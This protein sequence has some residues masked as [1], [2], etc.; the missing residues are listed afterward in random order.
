MWK[1]LENS[2]LNHLFNFLIFMIPKKIED[3]KSQS[4]SASSCQKK[5]AK[6]GI[7]THARN[8]TRNIH[9]F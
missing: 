5:M 1:K 6:D 9:W 2:F 7:Q 3:I 8:K 4:G